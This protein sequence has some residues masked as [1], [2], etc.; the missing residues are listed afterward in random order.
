[1]A[2]STHLELTFLGHQTWHITDGQST[3]LLDPFS[4]K[5]GYQP[6]GVHRVAVGTVVVDAHEEVLG[7]ANWHTHAHPVPVKIAGV[8]T[9][10]A[11]FR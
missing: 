2:A 11:C 9:C 3:V 7:Q 4:R 6:N 1:M 8:P 10:I 5:F